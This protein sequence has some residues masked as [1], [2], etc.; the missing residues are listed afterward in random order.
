MF[1]LLTLH[2]NAKKPAEPLEPAAPSRFS[3]AGTTLGGDDVPSRTIPDPNAARPRPA[4]PLTRILHLWEDGFSVDD[5]D[6]RRFDDPQNARD[7]E[8]IRSGRAPL[9]LMGA[10]SGQ[11]LDV[12]LNKHDEKYKKVKGAWKPFSGSGQRLGS[13]TP[14]DGSIPATPAPAPV[15]TQTAPATSAAT[16]ASI[17]P[18][19]PTLSLRLQLLDGTRLATRFNTTQTVGDVYD[20]INRASPGSSSMSWVLATTF[21]NKDHTDKTAVLGEMPEFKKGGTAVQKRT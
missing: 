21:P 20:F 13:P 11:A 8:M 12:Q 16:Q 4:Q 7:L 3:G 19:Q 9:H 5:G 15:S 17:D 6:L 2:R 1:Y 18:S 10:E 14:G